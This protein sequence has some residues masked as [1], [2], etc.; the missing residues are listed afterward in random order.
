MGECQLFAG[1]FLRNSVARPIRNTGRQSPPPPLCSG[2]LTGTPRVSGLDGG[3]SQ[4]HAGIQ[5]PTLDL[6]HHEYEDLVAAS[7]GTSHS[8]ASGRQRKSERHRRDDSYSGRRLS[9]R[10]RIKLRTEV[11]PGVGH[12]P[13]PGGRTDRPIG[14][15]QFFEATQA[16]TTT[17]DLGVRA[18]AGPRV[19][20][21]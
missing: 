17:R 16:E 10:V 19:A 3:Q 4:A 15:E 8:H 13:F 11:L 12:K 6:P 20:C 21:R 9:Y 14:C 5:A 1:F 7:G 18:I 2:L